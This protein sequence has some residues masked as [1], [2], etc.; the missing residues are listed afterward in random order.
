ME[1]LIVVFVKSL[2]NANPVIKLF[3]VQ[4]ELLLH[5][6]PYLISIFAS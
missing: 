5:Y 1:T 2:V 3:K 6:L 4:S